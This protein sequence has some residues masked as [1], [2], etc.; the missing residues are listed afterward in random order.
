MA[1]LEIR[2][3][4]KSFVGDPGLYGVSLDLERGCILCL[5]GPSGCGKTTLLRI[6]AGLEQADSGR[7][8]FDGRDMSAVPPHQR[9]FGMMFQEFALFPHKDVFENVAFGLRMQKEPAETIARRTAEALA[10]VGLEGFAS[11]NVGELS[12]GERQRVALARSLA[13]QPRLLMLDE[14]MGALDRALRE[15]LMVDIRRILKRVGMTSI[16]V[17][18][19]QAEAFAIADVIAVMNQG[20]VEQVAPPEELYRRPANATVARFLGFHN[21]LDGLTSN[22]NIVETSCGSF[23]ILDEAPAPGNKT[24]LLL[25]PDAARLPNGSPPEPGDTILEGILRDRTFLG[26]NYQIGLETSSGCFLL[27]ELPNEPR[28]PQPGEKIRLLIR[29][30]GLTLMPGNG[31]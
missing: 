21:L 17:T 4:I 14:P 11:R 2:D 16:F 12:G 25:R 5:L 26:R 29:P 20:R 13:P 22:G 7:V 15:R 30:T 18:H 23:R 3:I 24:V 31:K 27:F 9:N 10:L 19:D 1:L 6:V 28:P 8:L